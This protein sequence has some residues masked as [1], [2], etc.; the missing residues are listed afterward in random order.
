MTQTYQS[1]LA[2]LQRSLNLKVDQNRD[3]SFNS[4]LS[5]RDF[6]APLTFQNPFYSRFSIKLEF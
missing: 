4:P 2:N 1:Q 6:R 3:L 5:N